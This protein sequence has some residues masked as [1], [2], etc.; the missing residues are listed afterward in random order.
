MKRMQ[1]KRPVRSKSR[2]TSGEQ[3]PDLLPLTAREFLKWPGVFGVA[4]R[5]RPDDGGEHA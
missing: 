3:S 1:I 5:D 4:P 2:D